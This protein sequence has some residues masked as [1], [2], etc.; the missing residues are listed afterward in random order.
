MDP[1]RERQLDRIRLAFGSEGCAE[2]RMFGGNAF[3]LHGNMAVGLMGTGEL[4]VRVGPDAYEAALEAE[5]AR[6]M[7]FT[8][9]PMRGYVDVDSPGWASDADLQAWVDR[10]KEFA[11]TLPPK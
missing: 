4:M 9:K 11:G 1:E 2:R 5:H 7:D 3:M 8:G 10:G 6:P